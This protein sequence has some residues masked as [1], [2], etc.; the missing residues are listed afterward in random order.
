MADKCLKM[1]LWAA[2]PVSVESQSLELL[3]TRWYPKQMTS[4]AQRQRPSLG[5]QK[6]EQDIDK[7]S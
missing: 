3:V 1:S 5:E 4:L 7:G 2:L 6:S